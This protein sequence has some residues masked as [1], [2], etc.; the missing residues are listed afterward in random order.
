MLVYDQKL[1]LT[2][3]YIKIFF[4]ETIEVK[5]CSLISLHGIE[6]PG[7]TSSLSLARLVNI[8]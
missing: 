3:F 5:G 6:S 7:L 8:L 1:N 4:C 2:E